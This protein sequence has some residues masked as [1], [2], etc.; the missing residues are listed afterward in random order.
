MFLINF[1]GILTRDLFW[2]EDL[3]VA[4]VDV[5]DVYALEFL[6]SKNPS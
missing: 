2:C 1:Q 3:G 5:R 6:I 4:W